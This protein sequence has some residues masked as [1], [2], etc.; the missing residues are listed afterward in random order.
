MDPKEPDFEICS[1]V[2]VAYE[3]PEPV[4]FQPLALEIDSLQ[5]MYQVK[6]IRE[7]SAGMKPGVAAGP[8]GRSTGKRRLGN[9]E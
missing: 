7:G 5:V 2:A 3:S 8:G 9:R 4:F 6:P 1:G